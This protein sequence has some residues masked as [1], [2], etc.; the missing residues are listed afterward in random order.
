MGSHHLGRDARSRKIALDV[1]R[2][3]TRGEGGEGGE[4]LPFLQ[5]APLPV[6]GCFPFLFVPGEGGDGDG[7]IAVE[8]CSEKKDRYQAPLYL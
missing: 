7:G 6:I 4:Y 2:L 8:S 3:S 1:R 5:S